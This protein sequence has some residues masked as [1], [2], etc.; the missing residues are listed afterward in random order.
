MTDSDKPGAVAVAQVLHDLGWRIVATRG[1]KEAIERMGIPALEL[2]K[3]GDGSPNVVDWIESGEVD[4]VV[5]T[6]TGS[7]AR[8]DGSG[9][10]AGRRHP[11]HPVPDDALGEPGRG[12]GDRQRAARGARGAL[13]AGGPPR[14]ARGGRRRGR[15][16]RVSWRAV[17]TRLLWRLDPE[18]THHLALLVLRTLQAVPGLP[19]LL[20]RRLGPR[21]GALRVRAWDLEL[22]GPVAL[23]AGFDKDALGVDALG[24]LG[25][26][27]VEVGTVTAQ[28]QPGNPR[29]RLAR[30]PADRALVNRLG[31]NNRGAAAAAARLA[32]RRARAR[33][34]TSSSA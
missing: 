27:F 9:D 11:R 16:R 20:R 13:A 23:A 6:P 8:T 7:G 17:L 30:L 33:G 12:P 22:P 25:F 10:P 3:I 21:D 4:L 24:A 5:N 18:R 26:G 15:A 31:F 32:R 14:R 28:A 29:P 2:K 34:S 1:T 19:A